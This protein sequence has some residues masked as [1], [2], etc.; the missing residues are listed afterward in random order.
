MVNITKVIF[1]VEVLLINIKAEHRD[2]KYNLIFKIM[3]VTQ[4]QEFE[5]S[6]INSVEILFNV[7]ND[8]I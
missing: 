3:N 2:P 1:V 6:L 7:E 8:F 5:L 4:R